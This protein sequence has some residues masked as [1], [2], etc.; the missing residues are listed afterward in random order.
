MIHWD[1]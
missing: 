1:R